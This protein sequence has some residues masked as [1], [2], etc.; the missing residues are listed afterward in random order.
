MAY[1]ERYYFDT[2]SNQCKKFIYG[3]CGGN[4]NNF[5]SEEECENKCKGKTGVLSTANF[6]NQATIFFFSRFTLSKRCHED[7]K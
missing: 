5:N 2:E 3:G 1:F 7:S 6:Q 4:G